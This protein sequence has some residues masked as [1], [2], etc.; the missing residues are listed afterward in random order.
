M[1]GLFWELPPPKS[2]V[3]KA[4]P[5]PVWLEPDYLPGLDEA[6]AFNVPMMSNAEL[7]QAQ[8]EKHE[9]VCDV[10]IYGNYFL[11]AFMSMT[12]GKSTYIEII[13]EQP[14]SAP[15]LQKYLWIFSSFKIIT[16]N[17]IKFDLPII[18]LAANGFLPRDLK[19]A[20]DMLI[21]QQIEH[22]NVMKSFKCQLLEV[23]HIDLI[24]VAPLSGSLK[25]Y[26]GRLHVP[27][28]QDLPFPPHIDLSDDQITIMRYYCIN[29]LKTTGYLRFNLKDQ[30]LIRESMSE[31]YNLD[32]RSKSDAQIAEA[33][34]SSEL[35]KIQGF[36]PTRAK[37][38]EGYSF[39]FKIP[40]FIKFE[41]ASLN[42]YLD[43][44][45][46]NM[47]TL[48]EKG[49]V[50][51]PVAFYE[52]STVH[53]VDRKDWDFKKFK[54][55]K[56]LYKIGIGGL[57]ST[58]ES[59]AHK[60][61]ESFKLC[62]RDVNS[63]YPFAILLLRLY[64]GHLGAYFL[65][66][67]ETLV[68]KRM[69]AKEVGDEMME[70]MLGKVIADMLKIVIN[71]SFGKFGSKWS[72]LFAPDLLV[73][74][75]ITGQLSLLMLIERLELKGIEVVS[76]NTDGVVFKHPRVM[77]N[78]VDEIVTLWEKDTGFTTEETEYSAL[79]S[80]DVNNYI[81]IK[82]GGKTKGKGAY[83]SPWNDPK[84]AIFR[85]H[86]NPTSSICVEAVIAYLTEGVPIRD[87][88]T[89]CRDLTKFLTVR[90]VKGGG[91]KD[92]VYLGKA[93]RWYYAKDAG[94]PIIYAGS[95]NKV[96]KSDGARPCLDLPDSFPDD[97]DFER[98]EVDAYV[99]LKDIDAI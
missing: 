86:K 71:G 29:D 52:P 22:W 20:C 39:K 66:V 31:K 65:Q 88:I 7:L 85:F 89:T 75:T 37:L 5:T 45:R 9:L 38:D 2:K 95:G 74:T 40:D 58:E 72:V 59:T 98:Y 79:Y 26:G 82:P 15:D 56:M 99:I 23:D 47:F 33:V 43:I 96:P 67:Y 42:E 70:G 6:R 61:G 76:A 53:K 36:K 1:N 83:S 32:L 49:S 81:A 94:G 55:G 24:E 50:L 92:G 34:I 11:C 77:Q 62:E 19:H 64:P 69:R 73:Q 8:A 21:V 13:G 27:K 90:S 60:V 48:N 57:H 25:I 3:K 41:T 51:P 68:Y 84:S 4:P 44:L 54:V 97:L 17:G 87:T 12:T 18:S 14:M 91:V 16:F 28:M 93:I 35:E 46:N 10:E 80:R 30:L 78:I 63:Y